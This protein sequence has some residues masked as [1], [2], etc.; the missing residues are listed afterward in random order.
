MTDTA[1]HRAQ[2]A[3][4][5]YNLACQFNNRLTVDCS[6][7][8]A[9]RLAKHVSEAAY[10]T[11]N[12]ARDTASIAPDSTAAERSRAY[13]LSAAELAAVAA[14]TVLLVLQKKD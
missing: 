10:Q 3:Y 1:T 5:Q 8:D 4:R 9:A 6:A 12:Y 7:T 2:L 14:H 13:A 11:T